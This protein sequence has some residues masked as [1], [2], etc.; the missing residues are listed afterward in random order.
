[1]AALRLLLSLSFNFEKIAQYFERFWPVVE[2]IKD[3][4]ISFFTNLQALIYA[5]TIE[6]LLAALMGLLPF[7]LIFLGI[8]ALLRVAKYI[9]YFF[10]AI[11]IGTIIIKLVQ[12]ILF[13]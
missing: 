2:L 10:S 5:G 8:I 6:E 7:I 11:L 13:V 1:M 12:L 4:I 3:L 9:I